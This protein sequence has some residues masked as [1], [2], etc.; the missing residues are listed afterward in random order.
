M[1]DVDEKLPLLVNGQLDAS[2]RAELERQLGQDPVLAQE[3][4]FLAALRDGIQQQDEQTPG[5]LGLARLKREIAREKQH[6]RQPEAAKSYWK[7]VALTACALFALQTFM[8]NVPLDGR[9]GTDT[10]IATLAGENVSQ[11]PRLQLIFDDSATAAN[12]HS[13]LRSV[14]GTIVD[15]PGALGVYTLMLPQGADASQAVKQLSKHRFIEQV[16]AL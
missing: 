1:N 6:D 9:N 13:A 5:A 3:A 8:L 14:D 4:E 16:A 15:G 10:D 7:P 12:I 11:G 2:E